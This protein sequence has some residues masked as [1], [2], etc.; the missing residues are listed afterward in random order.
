MAFISGVIGA[1]DANGDR[2]DLPGADGTRQ[3]FVVQVGDGILPTWTNDGSTPVLALALDPEFIAAAA[4]GAGAAVA[5]IAALRAIAAADRQNGQ[6]R[7]VIADADGRPFTAIFKTTGGTGIA[8]DGVDVFIPGDKAIGD[9]DRWYRDPIVATDALPGR[10]TAAEKIRVRQGYGGTLRARAKNTAAVADLGACPV[11]QDGITLVA[12]DL[13]FLEGQAPSSANGLYVVGT[14]GG[15]T[16]PL[17]R[18]PEMAVGS[19]L[20]YGL[21][22]SIAAGTSGAGTVWEFYSGVSAVVGSNA[23]DWRQVPDAADRDRLATLFQFSGVPVLPGANKAVEIQAVLDDGN[24]PIL[25]PDGTYEIETPILFTPVHNGLGI[26]CPNGRALLVPSF[27]PNVSQADVATNALILLT[28]TIDGSATTTLAARAEGEETSLSLVASVGANTWWVIR[29]DSTDADAITATGTAIYREEL[30]KVVSVTGA[31]PYTAVLDRKLAQTHGAGSEMMAVT[32][33]VENVD[34]AGV[35][36]DCSGGTIAVGVLAQAT[37]GCSFDVRGAGFSRAGVNLQRGCR[38]S[39]VRYHHLG[40]SNCG[41]MIDSS[42]ETNVT[43][44]YDNSLSLGYAHANGIPRGGLTVIGRSFKTRARGTIG[45]FACGFEMKGFCNSLAEL[46]IE[47]CVFDERVSRD[48]TLMTAGGTK[49][50]GAAL[51]CNSNPSSPTND[52]EIPYGYTIKARIT[53]CRVPDASTNGIQSAVMVV[54]SVRGDLDIEIINTGR[55]PGATGAYNRGVTLYDSAAL[56]HTYLRRL[57]TKG[58]EYPL[59]LWG[60]GNRAVVDDLNVQA[61]AGLASMGTLVLYGDTTP[62]AAPHVQIKRLHT[63]SEPY[64]A[65]YHGSVTPNP[66]NLR[67]FTIGEMT[68]VQADGVV[69][70]IRFVADCTGLADYN[71][72]NRGDTVQIRGALAVT[73]D[74]GTDT[75]TA[76]DHW[77]RNGMP[78]YLVSA[79]DPGNY[80]PGTRL[81]VINSTRAAGAQAFQLSATLGGSAVNFSSNGT[82]VTLVSE[83]PSVIVPTDDDPR[84]KVNIVNGAGWGT[85]LSLPLGYYAAAFGRRREL[86][87]AASTTVAAGDQLVATVGAT[88]LKKDAARPSTSI[89]RTTKLGAAAIATVW[90]EALALQRGDA[91]GTASSL[92]ER[93]ASGEAVAAWFAPT[94]TIAAAGLLRSPYNTA[95]AVAKNAAGSGDCAVLAIG[96]VDDICIGEK[97]DGTVQAGYVKA[98]ATGYVYLSGGAQVYVAIGGAIKSTLT[99]SAQDF[100]LPVQTDTINEHTAATGVTIDGFKIKDNGPDLDKWRSHELACDVVDVGGVVAETIITAPHQA[101]TV[102]SCRFTND[103]AITGDNVNNRTF[104][105]YRR[106]GSGTQATIA[107]LTTTTG[108][109]FA[110]WIS[111]SLGSLSNTALAADE[112]LTCEVTAAGGGAPT[113]VKGVFTVIV[114]YDR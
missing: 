103:S 46:V 66:S 77:L 5:T 58:V 95:L 54:D 67:G 86:R 96:A 52:T 69:D 27:S 88:T 83:I 15:G 34:I 75:F 43:L 98:S 73:L 2:I 33:P 23:L 39:V 26:S 102:L 19:T 25:Q 90:G 114:T 56:D 11:V 62:S 61:N 24:L 38:G 37:D 108:V 14:V 85:G 47:D 72:L 60:G 29:S 64:L 9:P 100:A 78:V 112:V 35:D 1:Q 109:D 48:T 104:K 28:T 97:I 94:G 74:S 12:G 81:Y 7:T 76:T 82:T 13:F 22:V 30:V 40:E 3:P 55:S 107:S 70:D 45:R 44:S 113:N 32:A 18:A 111:K 99:S 89:A 16:A 63:D 36:F 79:T 20:L 31:G 80:T 10:L 105:V 6:T 4:E 49:I 68:R 91:I 84:T 93:G 92:L 65:A 51:N 59:I 8:D 57:V 42:H 41:V 110:A 17:T 50:G 53:D 106:N 87:V 101:C 71:G 21:R